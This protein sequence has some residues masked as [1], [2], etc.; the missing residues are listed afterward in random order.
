MTYYVS[1]GTINPTHSLTY[2]H[3]TNTISFMVFAVRPRL[4]LEARLVFETQLLLEEIRYLNW[5]ARLHF[6]LAV[7][8]AVSVRQFK[9]CVRRWRWHFSFIKPMTHRRENRWL[10]FWNVF[11]AN[12]IPLQALSAYRFVTVCTRVTKNWREKIRRPFTTGEPIYPSRITFFGKKSENIY[13]ARIIGADSGT[14]FGYY[15]S[16]G[17][18]LLVESRDESMSDFQNRYDIDTTFC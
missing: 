18:D 10:Y 17:R 8:A 3:M 15:S 5:R 16:L 7:N 14:V 2:G 1:S 4:L 11:H 12:T 6:T 13:S 9:R